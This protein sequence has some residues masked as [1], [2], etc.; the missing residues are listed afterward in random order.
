LTACL[1]KTILSE[2]MIED[3]LSR[4]KESAIK[5]TYKLGI[6]I[7]RCEDNGEKSTLKFIPSSNNHKEEET[8]KPTKTH[9]PSN[10]NPSF[11]P[12][13][14]VRKETP[15][16]REEAFICMF[17][18]CAGHLDEFCLCQKR[19]KK[20]HCEYARN[21]YRDEFFE[22]LPRSYSHAS[23]HTSSCDL[24]QFSHGPNHRSYVF[25]S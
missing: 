12:E 14:E 16:P 7:E 18:D 9:N 6:G 19:I 4:V 11:N 5:C 13:R 10:L 22:F 1:E 21:S 24:P 3:D 20:R 15:K 8:L 17:C 23:P 2:K 25:G